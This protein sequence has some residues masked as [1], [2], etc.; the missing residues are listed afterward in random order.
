MMNYKMIIFATALF[1]MSCKQKNNSLKPAFPDGKYCFVY[2]LSYDTISLDIN[3]KDAQVSGTMNYIFFEKATSHGTISGH[4]TENR[5]IAKYTSTD[6]GM[7]YSSEIIFLISDGE[8]NVGFGEMENKEGN[9][10]YKDT[11]T[12][13]FET[14]ALRPYDCK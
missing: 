10:V 7:D 2:T 14:F 4:L 13:K 12:L 1:V 9:L 11:S 5:L 3:V 6:E 8:L